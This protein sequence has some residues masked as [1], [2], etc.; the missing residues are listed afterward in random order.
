MISFVQHI[1]AFIQRVIHLRLN[2]DL[3]T[4]SLDAELLQHSLADTRPVIRKNYRKAGL[5][6]THNK[7][8][9]TKG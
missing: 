7:T 8:T 6:R 5:S 3:G 9:R 4:K 2:K 1:Y